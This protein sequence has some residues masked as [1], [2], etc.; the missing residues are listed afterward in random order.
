MA[1]ELNEVEQKD[2]KEI[3]QA[4]SVTIAIKKPLSNDNHDETN[5][6]PEITGAATETNSDDS[7]AM[8]TPEDTPR[9]YWTY[10]PPYNPSA[11]WREAS[12]HSALGL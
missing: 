11:E 1:I 3:I 4:E 7:T 10:R 6:T 9:D 2:D 8:L 12:R 5:A